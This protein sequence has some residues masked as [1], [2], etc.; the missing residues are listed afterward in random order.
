MSGIT[1]TWQASGGSLS[2]LWT[3]SGHWKPASVPGAADTALI[4]VGIVINNAANGWTLAVG[5]ISVGT[6]TVDMQE[7]AGIGT[8]LANGALI[9]GAGGLSLYSGV[10][11]DT[12]IALKDNADSTGANQFPECTGQ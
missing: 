6:V 3:T 12:G 2:G 5:T 9:A 11:E 4:G 7:G 1:A 10:I 8:L